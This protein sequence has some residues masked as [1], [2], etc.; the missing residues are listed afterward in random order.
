LEEIGTASRVGDQVLSTVC[1]V[2]EVVV[3]DCL[4]SWSSSACVKRP[5]EPALWC[6]L[7]SGVQYATFG[8]F[9][10]LKLKLLAVGDQALS[11]CLLHSCGGMFVDIW[12]EVR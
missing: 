5:V 2:L 6:V 9:V 11:S 7:A 3:V 1:S 4:W 12:I 10:S 8:K